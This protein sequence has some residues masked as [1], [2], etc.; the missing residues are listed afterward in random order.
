MTQPNNTSANASLLQLVLELQSL[1][2]V[3]RTGYNLRGIAHPESVSE[4]SFHLI[5]LVWS[6][7]LELPD[8]DRLRALEL[9]LIHDLAEV[10]TGDL[11]RTASHYLPSGAKAACELAVAEDLLA[12]IGRRGCD[13]MREYQAKETP[14]ARFVSCCDKLQLLLKVTM[15]E[16]WG[17]GGLAE[18]SA[19]LDDLSDGGFPPVARLIEDLKAWRHRQ[20]W[21]ATEPQED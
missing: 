10:R 6:L 4:H 12:P 14:E 16:R 3:P 15:Y 17:A 9:A 13:L 7:A 11:P 20:G 8:I 2:N 19:A 1:D 18:F 5:F 21:A